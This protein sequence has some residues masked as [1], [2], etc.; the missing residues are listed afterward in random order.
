MDHRI[1]NMIMNRTNLD[2]LND[3]WAITIPRDMLPQSPANHNQLVCPWVEL[4]LY[5]TDQ[6]PPNY[7]VLHVDNYSLYSG[8]IILL[9]TRQ[10]VRGCR[11]MYSNDVPSTKRQKK[12]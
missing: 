10:S 8:N 12:Q 6:L 1:L 9:V 7:T 3:T 4:P 5:L 11:D 2:P